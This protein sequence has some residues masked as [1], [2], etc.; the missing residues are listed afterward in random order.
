MKHTRFPCNSVMNDLNQRKAVDIGKGKGKLLIVVRKLLAGTQCT[1]TP[2]YVT[3]TRLL[4]NKNK[5]SS[6]PRVDIS[7]TLMLLRKR[8]KTDL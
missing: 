8:N 7:S 1:V 2:L 4:Y 5:F 3:Y 6:S